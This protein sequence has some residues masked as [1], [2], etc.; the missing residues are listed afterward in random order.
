MK[1]PELGVRRPVLTL[2]IFVG[3]LIVGA[4][5]LSQLPIDL[6]PKIDLPVMSVITFYRGASTE[7]VETRITKVIE[8]HVS[9]VPNVKEVSSVSEEGLSAVTLR[10]EWGSN[11]DEVAN[12]VR[13]GLDFAA[14]FLP[15]DAEEP[16][17]IKFDFSMMPILFFGVTAEESYPGLNKLLEEKF[18]DPLKRVPGVAMTLVMGGEQREIQVN[19]DRQ[20]LEA[21]HLSVGQITGILAAENLTQPAGDLKMGRTTY[22]LRVPGEFRSVE[23]IRNVVV[24]SASGVPIYLRDVAEVEDSFKEVEWRIRINRGRGALMMVQKQSGANT[25][26]VAERVRKALPRIESKLPSDVKVH[27]LMDSS[28]FI[29]RSINNLAATLGWALL[30]VMLVVFFFLR[31][32]RGSLIIALTIP[33]SLII[34]F[35]FLY[36]GGYTINMM[37]LSA[38]AIAIGMVVDNA[39]VIY[40]NAYRHRDKEGESRHEASIFGASEV[41]LAVTA[42]TL[43]TLAIFVPIIFVKGIAGIMF[44][45]LAFVVIVVLAGSLLTALLLTPM[46]ASRLMRIPTATT[47]RGGRRRF[48]ERSER[49]FTGMET[50]YQR[51]LGWTLGHRKTTVGIG[52][53]IFGVSLFM[54]RFVGTEFMPEMDQSEI[55]GHIELPVGTRVEATDQVM[56]QMEEIIVQDVPEQKMLFARCGVSESGMGSIM[57]RRSDTHIIMIGGRLVPKGERSRS[58]Q[59]IMHALG[60]K[61]TRIPGIKVIDFSQQDPMQAMSGGAKPVSVEIYGHDIDQTDA[62]ALKLRTMMEG[63]PGLTDI[64]ISREK[65][66]PELWI[67]VD[68]EKASTLG[69]NM[70]AIASALR[71]QFSG[72]VATKYREG[73]DEYDTFVRLRSPDRASIADLENALVTTPTGAQIPISSIAAVVERRGPLTIQRKDQERM[74]TVGAGLYKRPLGDVVADIKAGLAKMTFPEGVDVVIAGSAQDQEE[75]FRWLLLALILGIILVYMVMAAQF[76]SLLDPFV[77][78]FSIPFAITGVIWILLITG[79]TLNIISYVGMIMLVGIVVNNAIV[80]VDYTNIMRARGLSVHDAIL[81]AGR[82][83]LRPVLMTALTTIFGLL[84]LALRTGEGSEVWSPLAISVIGGLLVSTLITLIFVPTLYSIF[85]ERLK[86]KRVS[87][88]VGGSSS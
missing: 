45:E 8:S 6:M 7:D 28:D 39:I 9:T 27:L 17:L 71:T 81:T 2:M 32:F 15:E 76:E 14:R 74:V 59:E 11:L 22:V 77:I 58:S 64:T 65:G 57:G 43:T 5:S 35:I 85:E 61:A 53:A 80:L 4:I 16:S 69:L 40:E 70:A 66:K 13:Q 63:I 78:L 56:H 62:L 37:T 41:G 49:W 31:E 50:L 54:L 79:K 60:E 82:R 10:F 26:E 33:F 72:K 47:R 48:H 46:L 19:I 20:R 44:Q 25:L 42:S 23:E 68:R 3:I 12:D 84:P 51:I 75:S 52:L 36:L 29:R 18:G 1:L 38:L 83:R 21:Y 86:G 88:S 67:E 30:F 55:S 73:G 87:G 34:A 24:G